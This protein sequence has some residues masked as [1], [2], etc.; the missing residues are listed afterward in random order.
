MG[1]GMGMGRGS[2]RS[3][4]YL[5]IEICHS[6]LLFFPTLSFSYPL[7]YHSMHELLFLSRSLHPVVFHF[8]REAYGWALVTAHP[9]S[10]SQLFIRQVYTIVGLPSHWSRQDSKRTKGRVLI[11]RPKG[12]FL[13]SD[14]R[15]D[16][17]TGSFRTN[18]TLGNRRWI[19]RN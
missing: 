19:T 2:G 14:G 4:F 17:I 5:A 7:G 18:E 6:L 16:K 1:V 3:F 13:D 10:I 9:R 15:V 8:G 12:G 11:E